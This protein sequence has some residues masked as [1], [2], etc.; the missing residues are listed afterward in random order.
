MKRKLTYAGLA[1]LVTA[2]VGGTV[3]KI[4][5]YDDEGLVLKDKVDSET[6]D[7][8]DKV[9][10]FHFSAEEMQIEDCV[11][12]WDEANAQYSEGIKHWGMDFRKTVDETRAKWD[13]YY[14]AQKLPAET[15]AEKSERKQMLYSLLEAIEKSRVNAFDQPIWFHQKKRQSINI[16]PGT[17]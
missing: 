16:F 9:T 2:I 12:S 15:D 3:S 7:L 8:A 5:V 4:D 6:L 13:A 14:L 1:A 17:F 11:P 10:E